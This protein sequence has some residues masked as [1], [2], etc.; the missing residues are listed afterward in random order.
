MGFHEGAEVEEIPMA[1]IPG[2][3]EAEPE[4][5]GRD[6]VGLQVGVEPAFDLGIFGVLAAENIKQGKDA[7]YYELGEIIEGTAERHHDDEGES[8]CRERKR[9]G[10]YGGLGKS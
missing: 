8:E 7:G 6:L 5:G 3:G 1:E 9:T 4:H 2:V 10:G